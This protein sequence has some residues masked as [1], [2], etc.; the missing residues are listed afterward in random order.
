MTAQLRGVSRHIKAYHQV[1]TDSM[2]S[3]ARAKL[4][5]RIIEL[6]AVVPATERVQRREMH[7]ECFGD[8]EDF[9]IYGRFR[10]ATPNAL[11]AIEDMARERV[12]RLPANGMRHTLFTCVDVLAGDLGR[13]F[14]TI[15]KWYA[16]RNG[17]VFDAR[18]P[19]MNGAQFRPEDLLRDFSDAITAAAKLEWPTVAE[20]RGAIESM[21]QSVFE[22]NTLTGDEGVLK[23]ED[24]GGCPQAEIAWEGP[25][26]VD[27]AIEVW[28]EGKRLW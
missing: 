20:A 11:R 12:D 24:C 14:F 10:G 2:T 8:A 22:E 18:E 19:L 26:P 3:Q 17:L 23:L 28:R 5:E 21:L 4:L 25:V 15:G 27:M 6:G 9:N 7:E 13:I 16:I 1:G